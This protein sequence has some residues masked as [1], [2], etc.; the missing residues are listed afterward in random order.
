VMEGH[1]MHL[2]WIGAKGARWELLSSYPPLLLP[3]SFTPLPSP[4]S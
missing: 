2:G 3:H 4:L 1:L